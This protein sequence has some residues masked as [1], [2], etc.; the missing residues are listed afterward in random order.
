[1]I[2]KMLPFQFIKKSPFYGSCQGMNYRII[3]K[4]E[5]LEACVFPGPYNYIKTSE[6]QKEYKIFDFS[7][8][9]YD[10]AIAWLNE[11]YAERTWEK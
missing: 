11:K 3:K 6:E 1:M 10:A 8:K 2:E 4:G 7:E 5:K 9:G